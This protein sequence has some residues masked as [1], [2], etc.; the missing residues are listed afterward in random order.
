VSRPGD[1]EQQE[2]DSGSQDRDL[3]RPKDD[4]ARY[5][6]RHGRQLP[7]REARMQAAGPCPVITVQG[8]NKA[9]Q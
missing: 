6:F 9:E 4:A 5:Q 3:H 1:E 8:L 2:E 7:C